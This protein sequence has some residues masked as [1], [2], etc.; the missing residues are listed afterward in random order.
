MLRD[1]PE[2]E[3]TPQTPHLL[4]CRPAKEEME[5]PNVA[6][7]VSVPTAIAEVLGH[8]GWERVAPSKHTSVDT[9]SLAATQ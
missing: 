4:L 1:A 6:G 5:V 3:G 9:P 7:P 2:L 8:I